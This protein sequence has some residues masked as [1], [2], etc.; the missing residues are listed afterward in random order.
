MTNL[1]SITNENNKKWSYIPDHP[2]RIL[3]IN[4]SG[5]G[6][7]DALINL[8]N[9]QDY[10]DK[11]YFYAKDLSEYEI[12]I[13]KRKDVGIKH[14]NDPNAFIECSNTMDDVYENIHDYNSSRKRKILIV[15]DDMI[16]DIMTNKKFQ[17]I[18][19]ELFIRCRKLNISLAFITQSLFFCSKR[20]QIKFN[21]LFDYENQQQKRI[22]KYCN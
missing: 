12:F 9:E 8:I 4:A 21:T 2:Y 16:A 15:F 11:I 13:K 20:R 14:L 17:A 19:K 6:K 10:I 18:I 1:D 5:S 3:I 22:T 7:I